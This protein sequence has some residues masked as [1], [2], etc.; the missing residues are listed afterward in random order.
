MRA[1]SRAR[2]YASTQASGAVVAVAGCRRAGCSAGGC[3]DMGETDAAG[4]PAF[5]MTWSSTT[6]SG[7]CSQEDSDSELEQYF[8]ARTSLARKP[9]REQVG[10]GPGRAWGAVAS[11]PGSVC[12]PLRAEASSSCFPPTG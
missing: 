8:T 5:E 7:Y 12:S 9:R 10:W 4:T 6:S 3:T 11:A 1:L 2:A